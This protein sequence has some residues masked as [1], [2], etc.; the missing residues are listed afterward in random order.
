MNNPL[1]SADITGFTFHGDDVPT[2]H[3]LGISVAGGT[4]TAVLGGSGSGKSTLGRLL[5][6]WLRPGDAG[7]LR[8][9]LTLA[10]STL[11]FRGGSGD[12]RIDAAAWSGRVAYVPQDPASMLSTVSATVAEELA[13]GLE[14][15]GTPRPEML[16]EVGRNAEVLGLTALLDR[17]PA[18]LS[19]G[20]LRRLALGCALI[21]RP[22]VLILDEPVASLDADGAA[23]LRTLVRGLTAA[24]TAVVQLSQSADELARSADHWV[25]LDAGTVTAAGRPGVVA[26]SPQLAATGV[27]VVAPPGSAQPTRAALPPAGAGDRVP[28]LDVR[29]LSFGYPAPDAPYRR[30]LLAGLDLVVRAG[31][32]VA[33]TGPNGAGKST[34]LRS[35]N[36]LLRPTAGEIRIRGGSIAGVPAGTLAAEIGL[37]FQHP[38]DQLFERTVLREVSFGLRKLLGRERAVARAAEALAAVGLAGAADAHPAELASSQQ[39]LLALATVL[40]RDPAVLALDEPTVGLDR[41]GLEALQAAAEAAAARGAAIVLVTHDLGYAHRTAR[42]VLELRDGRLTD[43]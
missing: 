30:Q 27:V 8:G 6:G 40:A 17:D 23:Q 4:L 31:E 19:G 39:R 1:L 18:T 41:H 21:T 37:L 25:V 22:D 5:G 13:F 36:G 2:L 43:A 3:R 26:A 33:I 32:T 29:G 11:E 42:R 20:E 10:G 35:L 16:Q 34:L 12:P 14:N 9:R 7:D 24:G 15:R 28:Q 38:R